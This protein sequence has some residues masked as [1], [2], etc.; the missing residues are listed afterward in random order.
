MKKIKRNSNFDILRIIAMLMIIIHHCT[1]NDFELQKVLLMNNKMLSD[2]QIITLIGINSLVI[3]G[4]NLFFLLS[5]YF[6]INFK[7]KKFI[8]YIFQ[9]YLIFDIVTLIGIAVGKVS[10]DINTIKQLLNPLDTYWFLKVYLILMLMSPILNKILDEISKD[11]YKKVIVGIVLLFS[12]YSFYFDNSILINGGYSLIWGVM[13]YILGAM[14]QKFEIKNKNGIIGYFV[15]ALINAI[16]ISILY[17]TNNYISAW[18]RFKYNELLVLLESLSLI[19]WFNSFSKNKDSNKAIQLFA[20]STLVVYL[21]HSSCWLTTMRSY[22][23]HRIIEFGYFRIGIILLPLYALFIYALC[24][25]IAYLY[26]LTIQKLIDRINV[27]I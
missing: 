11:N 26:N 23:I 1:I 27:E 20:T 3:I 15:F 10:W 14:I 12:I 19:V 22:P 25:L 2:F 17:K 5:G 13:L 18:N 9:I 7:W 21:L 4:V 16:I 6:R 24:T 8:S